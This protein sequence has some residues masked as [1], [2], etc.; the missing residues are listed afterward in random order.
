MLI[1]VEKPVDAGDS[2]CVRPQFKC[3]TNALQIEET[4]QFQPQV[5]G[6]VGGFAWHY[7]AHLPASEEASMHYNNTEGARHRFFQVLGPCLP[8]IHRSDHLTLAAFLAEPDTRWHW[9]KIP[10]SG[11][12]DDRLTQMNHPGRPL[13]W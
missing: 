7:V 5:R 6:E 8:S 11:G 13:L 2:V 9:V 3:Y 12:R 4:T 1:T 10:L